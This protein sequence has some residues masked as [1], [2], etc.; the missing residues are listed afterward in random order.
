MRSKLDEAVFADH[1]LSWDFS[2][3]KFRDNLEVNTNHF[4]MV[5]NFIEKY[6]PVRIMH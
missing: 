3:E 2:L 1:K 5:E 4:A 6:I